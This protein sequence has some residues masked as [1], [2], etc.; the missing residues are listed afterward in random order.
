MMVARFLLSRL[1][2]SITA[3]VFLLACVW[4]GWNWGVASRDAAAKTTLAKGYW[5]EIYTEKTG[6][7]DRLTT[8]QASLAGAEASIEIQ[9]RA[10]DALRRA[11]DQAT[12]A[13]NASIRLAQERAQAAERQSLTI[14]QERPR[15]GESQ[16]DAAFRLHQE[17]VQ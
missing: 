16:C 12:A 2:L 1:G 5:S 7:R 17:N 10:V 11:G 6:Y 14:L 15:E 8:C 4:T 3:S 13:A 9:N